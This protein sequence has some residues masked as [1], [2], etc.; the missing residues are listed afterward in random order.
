MV[1]DGGEAELGWTGDGGASTASGSSD[2]SAA[3]LVN[4]HTQEAYFAAASS[5]GSAAP[6]ALVWVM[7]GALEDEW[8]LQ[9]I[10]SDPRFHHSGAPDVAF[11]EEGVPEPVLEDLR[12]WGHLLRQAPHLGRVNALHCPNS[13]ERD[14]ASCHFSNDPRGWGLGFVVQ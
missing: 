7:L 8:P 12:G 6:T 1:C 5:G 13:F 4:L 11:Y 10:L 2:R 3:I 14:I 9:Q